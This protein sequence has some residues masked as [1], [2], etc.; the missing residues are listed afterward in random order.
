MSWWH[1]SIWGLLLGAGTVLGSPGCESRPRGVASNLWPWAPVAVEFH[2]LSRFVDR[3]GVE[4][5]SLRLE[6]RDVD[7]DP[8][9]FPGMVTLEVDP[10]IEIDETWTFEY[11][12]GQLDI[13]AT[14]WDR[15]TSTYRFELEVG[16]TDPP[17]PGT[18]IRV[19]VEAESSETGRLEA[20]ITVRRL[21]L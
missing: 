21:E 15:V 2:D 9:K 16:W 1:R 17:L 10:E 7:G 13:N 3:N 6:F 20:G 12:L 14:H 8:V 19:R 11:D 5:L 18:P 4:L